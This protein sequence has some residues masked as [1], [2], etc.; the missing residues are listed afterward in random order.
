MSQFQTRKYAITVQK[1]HQ[2]IKIWYSMI[3]KINPNI[4]YMYLKVFQSKELI[5]GV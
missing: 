4:I 1:Q 5:F 3:L 2:N